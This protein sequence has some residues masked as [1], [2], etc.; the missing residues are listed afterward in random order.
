M[1]VVAALISYKWKEKPA[2]L[3]AA[4]C[5]A[6]PLFGTTLFFGFLDELRDYYEIYPILVLLIAHSIG[7]L[8]GLKI[9]LVPPMKTELVGFHEKLSQA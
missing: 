7:N 8:L 2:F 1:L 3:K 9:S 5:I 6:V 4:L